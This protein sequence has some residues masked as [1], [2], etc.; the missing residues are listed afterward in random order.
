MASQPK[1]QGN[2]MLTVAL[3][4]FDVAIWIYVAVQLARVL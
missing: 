1:Q 2:G 3:G 4:M